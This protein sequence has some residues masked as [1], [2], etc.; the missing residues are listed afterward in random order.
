M[1]WL[2]KTGAGFVGLSVLLYLASMQST[3]GLLFLL[4]G[5]VF[6]CF[7]INLLGARQNLRQLE[8]VLPASLSGTEGEPLDGYAT[9]RNRGRRNGGLAEVTGQMGSFL[10][11]GPLPPQETLQARSQLTMP[12]RGLYT[13]RDLRLSSA[14]PF[15]LIRAAKRLDAA[16][17][18]VVYPRVYPCDSP[19]ASGFE[20]VLGGHFTGPNRS[21]A[22]DRFHGVRPMQ[23]GDPVR[24]VHWASSSKGLG[25]MVKEFEEEL[26][27]RVCLIIDPAPANAADGGSALDWAARAA[28]SLALATL[29]R[30]NQLE[31]ASSDGALRLSVPPFADS[32]VV[33]E[34]LARLEERRCK[35]TAEA[36][37]MLVDGL[38]RKAS[39][40]FVMTCADPVVTAF[41]NE[42]PF[43][44]RRVMTVYLPISAGA[45]RWRDGLVARRYDSDALLPDADGG[46]R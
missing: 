37:E 41:I 16:G 2:T 10:K 19:P 8:V 20:P 31:L 5:V 34:A 42:A 17:E 14:F 3:T 36:L 23:D 35:L 15:G 40:C 11:I 33:L 27:G 26:A 46:W 43:L 29:D 7:V 44:R 32:E 18:I 24:L 22:G 30:G 25:L 12:R 21:P 39:L 13:Y 28:G 9:V 6:A 4:L 38:P 1:M 45:V